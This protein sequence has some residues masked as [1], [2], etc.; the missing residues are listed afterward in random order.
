MGT[1]EIKMS[2]QVLINDKLFGHKE[3][4]EPTSGH[5]C[6][7]NLTRESERF[8]MPLF[9]TSA[10]GILRKTPQRR[11]RDGMSKINESLTNFISA[12]RTINT[13]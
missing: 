13:P 1:G 6:R 2:R 5:P 11:K 3:F 7:A 9:W 4:S 10:V 8:G 12:D